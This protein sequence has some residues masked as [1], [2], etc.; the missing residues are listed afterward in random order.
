MLNS[1]LV[2]A[3]Y[4]AWGSGHIVGNVVDVANFHLSQLCTFY[5]LE[6]SSSIE[7]SNKEDCDDAHFL[8]SESHAV[9]GGASSVA[10]MLS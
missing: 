8:L 1:L 7:S 9:T 5:L 3:P 10:R 6:T 2:S 4:K